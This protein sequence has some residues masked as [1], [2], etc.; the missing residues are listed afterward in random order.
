M[1]NPFQIEEIDRLSL[2]FKIGREY[3]FLIF[4]TFARLSLSLVSLSLSQS[5]SLYFFF[6]SKEKRYERSIHIRI[7]RM[8]K[9]R[10]TIEKKKV[11]DTRAPLTIRKRENDSIW[12][13]V[14]DTRRNP[15]K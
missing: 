1:K 4:E 8:N 2:V 14:I 10:R 12:N 6:S 7:E 5:F 11:K 3:T 13:G 15:K 9:R